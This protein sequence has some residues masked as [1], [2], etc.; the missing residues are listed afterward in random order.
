[1]SPLDFLV[2]MSN[3]TCPKWGP[4]SLL[5]KLKPTLPAVLP[6]SMPFFQ[7]YRAKPWSQPLT[8]PL[9]IMYTQR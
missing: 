4:P 1:M 6:I 2:G 9:G 3:V 7:L 5:H 8:F